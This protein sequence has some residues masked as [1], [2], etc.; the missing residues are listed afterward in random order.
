MAPGLYAARLTIGD[1]SAVRRLVSLSGAFTEVPL[2]N[3]LFDRAG[4]HL[5]TA[6]GDSV[7]RLWKLGTGTPTV[8][9]R[10][11]G[12]ARRVNALALSADGKLLASGSEDGFVL[13]WDHE[14][15]RVLRMIALAPL[16]SPDSLRFPA[17]LTKHE[18]AT[19]ESDI[20]EN[21]GGVRSMA[22]AYRSA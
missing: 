6:G 8:V 11:Q 7:I 20:E 5:I 9:A 2:S 16:R 22:F 14:T 17:G 12:H 13:I 4:G 3:L 19:V 18:L 15:R 1:W 21:Y 10:L